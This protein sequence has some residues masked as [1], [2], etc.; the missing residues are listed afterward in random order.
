MSISKVMTTRLISVTPT[1]N[2]ER[3]YEILRKLPIH[4]ILVVEE[5]RLLGIV[6]DRD[7]LRRVSPF[8][9]TKSEQPRDR[10]TLQRQASQIMTPV[11]ATIK[12]TQGIRQAAKLMLEK[13]VGLLP[14]VDEE[15]L[16][17]GVLSWK[18]VLRF[19][20]E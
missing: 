15:G 2:L 6:S 12:V 3:M 9:N 20:V 5:G 7:V 13:N 10:F 16:L 11:P 18:D 19:I 8:L 17:I 1:D 4:H 14:V